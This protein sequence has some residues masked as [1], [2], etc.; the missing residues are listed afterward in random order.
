MH[1]TKQQHIAAKGIA[2]PEQPHKCC[3]DSRA[4]LTSQ[5]RKQ[6]SAVRMINTVYHG[7]AATGSSS[8]RIQHSADIHTLAFRS[9]KYNSK[10]RMQ[11]NNW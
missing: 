3:I 8:T 2:A 1:N 7:S 5:R 9:I 10:T 4:V 11:G 6:R